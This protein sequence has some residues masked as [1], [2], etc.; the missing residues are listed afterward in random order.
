MTEAT[1]KQIAN[2]I[3]CLSR[4]RGIEIS[5]LK[6]QKLLYYAQAWYL[7]IEGRPLFDEDIEAWVHGPVVASIFRD[8][9]RYRW[10]PIDCE[11]EV[12]DSREIR[13]FV[14]NVIQRYGVF[15]A[16][17]LERLTHREEPWRAAR[18]GLPPDASSR[19]I[20]SKESMQ[21]FYSTL[22]SA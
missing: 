9:K 21:R 10:Q 14:S 4:Q 5:N 8:F 22:L 16:T 15:T 13:N 7:A 12:V 18:A 2:T 17:Q 3:I 6:L 11:A 19:N 1:A 20:I